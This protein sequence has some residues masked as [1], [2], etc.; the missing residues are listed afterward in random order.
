MSGGNTQQAQAV[1]SL[2]E[3][4]SNEDTLRQCNAE[5]TT[6]GIQIN[7]IAI[8]KLDI[9]DVE[10]LRALAKGATI[11]VAIREKRKVAEVE[12]E[13]TVL[14]ARANAEG[15]RLEAQ[16]EAYAE[17][18]RADAQQYYAE[19]VAASAAVLG[20]HPLAGELMQLHASGSVLAQTQ[21]S[22]IITGGGTDVASTLLGNSNV[23]GMPSKR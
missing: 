13:S 21:S 15:R 7:K 14:Q 22:L 8:V 19:K 20:E 1:S 23:V 18:Q 2:S 4:C 12:A 9:T 16:A 17:R 11:A 5:L 10:V 3:A 6:I